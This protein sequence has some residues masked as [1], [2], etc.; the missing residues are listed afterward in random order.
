MQLQ[1]LAHEELGCGTWIGGD[2]FPITTAF[3]EK[4]AVIDI[5]DPGHPKL[6][7]SMAATRVRG[8]EVKNDADDTHRAPGE[9]GGHGANDANDANDANGSNSAKRANG[10]ANRTLSHKSSNTTAVDV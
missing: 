8:D 2:R 1:R 9:R 6:V 4:L 5:S 10:D 7:N 3:G